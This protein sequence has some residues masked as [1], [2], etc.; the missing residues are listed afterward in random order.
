VSKLGRDNFFKLLEGKKPIV[1][2][3]IWI[4]KDITSFFGY[5]LSLAS[6]IEVCLKL[7][8]DLCFFSWNSE[9]GKVTSCEMNELVSKA[10]ENNLAC[11]IVIDGIFERSLTENDFV[12]T[13]TLL[14]SKDNQDLQAKWK[15]INSQV[16]K[17]AEEA[18]LAGADLVLLADDLAFNG[19]LYFS[20]DLF[21]AN[22]LP[23]YREFKKIFPSDFPLAFHSDGKIEKIMPLLAEN[24]FKIFSVEPDVIDFANLRHALPKN[25]ILFTGIK[26]SWLTGD[27][28]D[29]E[30]MCFW[31]HFFNDWPLILGSSC[32]LFRKEIL[33]NFFKIQKI[34]PKIFYI[35]R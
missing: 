20:P 7:N 33:N 4:S 35:E 13:L 11:G 12:E 16:L 29:E 6:L 17:E 22:I 1:K 26:S 30:I 14:A 3:E 31:Q 2:G 27:L 15:K 10:K 9:W 34:A 32:G 5:P 21:Q 28:K 24:G 8:L 18:Y 19:G 25:S 23:F